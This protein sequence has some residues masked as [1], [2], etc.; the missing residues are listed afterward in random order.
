MRMSVG[1]HEPCMFVSASPG[2]ELK[3]PLACTD[4]HRQMPCT[5][6]PRN[7]AGPCCKQHKVLNTGRS[8]RS[9]PAK[10]VLKKGSAARL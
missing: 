7:A 9:S 5:V 4:M 1:I 6:L 8:L 2:L 10:A 3:Y